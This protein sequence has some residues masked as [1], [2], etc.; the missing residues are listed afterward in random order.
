MKS[1]F[2]F[3]LCSVML[4]ARGQ[5]TLQFTSVNATDEGGIRLA[6]QSESNTVY[7]VEYATD[8]VDISNGG[9]AWQTIYEHYPSHGTNTFWLDTGNYVL[10]PSVVHPRSAPLRFYRIV[11]EG[12]DTG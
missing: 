3:A 12:V 8:L 7:R 11:N 1:I 9:P 10:D 2:L 4:I 5:S 6:W